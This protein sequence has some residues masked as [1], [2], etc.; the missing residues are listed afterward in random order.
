[1]CRF[2]DPCSILPNEPEEEYKNYENTNTD[3]LGTFE[4][5]INFVEIKQEN[6]FKTETEEFSEESG[7][8]LL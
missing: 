6:A 5:E 4:T 7:D 2:E 1:M 8:P 3:P